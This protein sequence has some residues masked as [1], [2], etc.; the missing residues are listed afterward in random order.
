MIG[1]QLGVAEIETY[2]ES[3]DSSWVSCSFCT[4]ILLIKRDDTT[5]SDPVILKTLVRDFFHTFSNSN[6]ANLA[7]FL[8]RKCPKPS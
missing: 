5:C 6:F 4:Q 7:M 1:V 2:Q 8:K 3:A